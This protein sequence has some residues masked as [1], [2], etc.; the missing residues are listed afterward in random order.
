MVELRWLRIGLAVQVIIRYFDM[1]DELT[2]Y[3][4]DE[5]INLCV[6]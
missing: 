6:K 1:R 4:A 2:T 3:G 5:C